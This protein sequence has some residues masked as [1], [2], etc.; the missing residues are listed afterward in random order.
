MSYVAEV[1][2]YDHVN[3]LPDQFRWVG[4]AICAEFKDVPGFHY[5]IPLPTNY[6]RSWSIGI[7]AWGD[8]NFH[9]ILSDTRNDNL[10]EIFNINNRFKREKVIEFLKEKA[11]QWKAEFFND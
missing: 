4:E 10:K 7:F 11:E 2:C 3:D 8:R 5:L 9:L 1:G 6:G